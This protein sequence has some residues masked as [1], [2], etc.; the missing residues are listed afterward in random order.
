MRLLLTFFVKTSIILLMEKKFINDLNKK[1]KKDEPIFIEDI[2]EALNEYSRATIF[3][4]IAK[5]K[6]NDE[7]KQFSK[8]IYYLPTKTILNK[9][10][11]LSN[12]SVVYKRFL[13][14]E[15]DTVCGIFSGIKLLNDFNITTQVPNAIEIVTNKESSR[16]REVEIGGIRYILRKSRTEITNENYNA[17]TVLEILN[18]LNYDEDLDE[19]SKDTIS[20]YIYKTQLSKDELLDMSTYFPSKAGRKLR[21]SGVLNEIRS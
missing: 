18:N 7:L 2:L 11:S 3:R 10:S 15:N 9:S 4:N 12:Y 8:G 14:N 13:R 20:R 5:A 6:E 16:K 1:F 19:E 21:E 17:Y